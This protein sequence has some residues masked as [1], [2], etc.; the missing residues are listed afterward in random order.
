MLT[1]GSCP[2]HKPVYAGNP[3]G[4]TGTIASIGA[5][6][7][8]VAYSATFTYQDPQYFLTQGNGPWGNRTW[9]YDRTGNRLTHAETGDAT[10]TYTYVQNG[11]SKNTSR[12][13]RITPAPGYGTGF[14]QFTYD[15]AG[16]ETSILEND[17]EGTFKTIF[18][19]YS[20]ESQISALRSSPDQAQT[21]MLYDGRGFLRQAN[22]TFTGSTDFTKVTPTYS[23]EGVLHALQEE[24]QIPPRDDDADAPVSNPPLT[25]NELTTIFYFAGRPIAQWNNGG[26]LLYLTTDHLGTPVLAT[27]DLGA[28]VWAGG[29]E[30]FGKVWSAGGDTPD[31]ESAEAGGSAG[32]Q[33][34][35]LSRPT[36]DKVFLRYPGQWASDAFRV[37]PRGNDL[38][39]NLFR[40][41]EAGTGRYT[42]VDPVRAL[43][44]R[45]PT[46]NFVYAY[47]SMRPMF[48]ADPLGLSPARDPFSRPWDSGPWGDRPD[49]GC[50]DQGKIANRLRKLN[51]DLREIAKGRPPSGKLGSYT[52]SSMWCHPVTQMCQPFPPAE[53]FNPPTFGASDPCLVFCVRVHEWQHRVDDRTFPRSLYLNPIA[54]G[55]FREG[56]GT[57]AEQLCLESFR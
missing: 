2:T 12:L 48:L 34:A 21:A 46:D 18:R 29:V 56:P 19:D 41:Y 52:V 6:P 49:G 9:T 1:D 43:D 14:L 3:T 44:L 16:N 27:S 45:R 54:F 26:E 11:S 7:G 35:V 33:E 42:R 10:Q 28:V 8:N 40:W 51:D 23:S 5:V 32:G 31:P 24:R 30:P 4:I 55:A 36:S 20:E 39:Y 37:D 53:P 13:N 17:G 50:C 25:S 38:Y 57:Q 15:P 22:Q 47:A